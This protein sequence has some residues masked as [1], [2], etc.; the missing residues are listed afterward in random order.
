MVIKIIRTFNKKLVIFEKF[1]C[2][3]NYK[4]Q[5]K[6][7]IF[8]QKPR[9]WKLTRMTCQLALQHFT[10]PLSEITLLF[11]ERTIQQMCFLYHDVS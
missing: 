8:L 10:I 3:H 6:K 1:T 5:L 11:T 9:K 7:P 4:D 2:T